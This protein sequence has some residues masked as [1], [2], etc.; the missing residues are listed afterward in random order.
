MYIPSS[1]VRVSNTSKPVD[2]WFA[3]CMVLLTLST[4]RNIL[5]PDL[6][7]T[8]NFIAKPDRFSLPIG[9]TSIN[10]GV[11]SC[12]LTSAVSLI[13]SPIPANKSSREISAAHSFEGFSFS[14]L[15]ILDSIS[16][17]EVIGEVLIKF[18]SCSVIV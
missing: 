13:V 11:L 9:A 3:C 5:L 15:D 1:I 12:P 4:G 10:L 17:T 6:S 16:K 2:S 8:F 18:I 14:V 7:L